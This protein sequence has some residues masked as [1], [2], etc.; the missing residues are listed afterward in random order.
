MKKIASLLLMMVVGFQC[1][2]QSEETEEIQQVF[3]AFIS[4]RN[5][6]VG[7]DI[8]A[9]KSAATQIKQ[10]RID[11]F[12]QLLCVDDSNYSI[13]GHLVFDAKFADSLS[14]DKTIMLKSDAF[15]QAQARGQF[16]DGSIHTKT[17]FVKA[18]SVAKYKFEARGHQELGVVAEAGGLVTMKVHVTNNSGLDVRYDDRDKVK[19]GRPQR[20][21]AFEM[22]KKGSCLV[23]LEV[24]NCSD[25]DISF[26]VISN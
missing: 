19:R 9:I 13:N 14:K 11:V 24:V 7:D 20:K 4:F 2:A 21:V 10:C 12:E 1:F 17:C 6:A 26:V 3:D 25:K 23:E 18:R 15:L 16:N 22:P 5:A 8:D